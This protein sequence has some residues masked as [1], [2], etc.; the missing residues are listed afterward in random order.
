MPLS[1]CHNVYN[2]DMRK[3]YKAYQ[4]RMDLNRVQRQ[5]LRQ[6]AGCVRFVYNYFKELK[7]NTYRYKHASVSEGMCKAML[8]ELKKTKGYEWLKEADSISLQFAI[9]TLFEAYDRFYSGQNG[10]PKFKRRKENFFSYTTKYVNN[11]IRIENGK[12]LL[13]KMGAVKVRGLRT[14][15]G[16]IKRATV[17]EDSCGNY[18]VSILCEVEMPDT[19]RRPSEVAID[20]GIK[21][22]AVMSGHI[23]ISN[24]RTLDK[25]LDKLSKE[26]AKLSR[27]TIGSNRYEEQRIK[28]ARLHKKVS[29]IR[30]DFQH[31]LSLNIVKRYGFIGIEDLDVKS[32]SQSNDSALNR[33]IMDCA[34]AS[35][36]QKL[37]YKAEWY[38]SSLVRVG[39]Y[40]P[41]SQ[42]CSYCREK[43]PDVKDIR[44]REWTCPQCGHHHDRDDNAQKNILIEAKHIYSRSQ[45]ARIYKK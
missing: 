27:K 3:M 32:M 42:I 1:L 43:N 4:F 10:F 8:T 24:P 11:N 40:Y 26:Q 28:V 7:D 34:W 6:N 20:L 37:E 23:H 16:V 13:P 33:R 22:Y 36:V 18:Y 9:E 5:F 38:G 25:Y 19:V 12:L 31:K 17:S 45:T 14:L 41:S 15:D 30:N 29:N 44:I 2:Y 35:F 39:R 21:D